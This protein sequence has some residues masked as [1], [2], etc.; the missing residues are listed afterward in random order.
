MGDLITGP[1][2]VF[3]DAQVETLKWT[4]YF[5]D[6]VQFV[7]EFVPPNRNL[8]DPLDSV[9]RNYIGTM[10]NFAIE[11]LLVRVLT[12]L[13]WTEYMSQGEILWPKIFVT[14]HSQ[15]AS[16]V[17]YVAYRRPVMGALMFSGPQD[18]CGDK[19]VARFVPERKHIYGCYAVDEPGATAI[20]SNLQVFREVRAVNSTGRA[21][22]HGEG[23]WCPPPPHCATAVDDQLVDDSVTRCFSLLRNVFDEGDG[24]ESP[25]SSM[26]HRVSYHVALSLLT[27][28]WFFRRIFCVYERLY[29]LNLIACSQ[30]NS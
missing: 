2:P 6:E 20:R 14:G 30:D 26:S 18:M 28:L 19:G 21:R 29:R 22:N 12:R 8:T 3:G 11:V 9:A 15:G 25:T 13:G 17:S 24:S 5:A 10:R 1:M 27:T 4:H 16:H 23:V 7:P